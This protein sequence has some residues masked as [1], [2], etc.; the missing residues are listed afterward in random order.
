M[1]VPQTFERPFHH[2]VDKEIRPIELHYFRSEPLPNPEM[3][4]FKRDEIVK[5]HLAT[6]HPR[7]RPLARRAGRLHVHINI[8]R[9]IKACFLRCFDKCLYTYDRHNQTIHFGGWPERR[10]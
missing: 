10:A 1:L 2:L 5:L 8:P 4:R 6:R 7:N 3:P 9:E